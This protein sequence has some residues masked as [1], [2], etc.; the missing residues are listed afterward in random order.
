ME[1]DK[2]PS[3]LPPQEDRLDTAYTRML[4][5]LRGGGEEGG[6][7][8]LLDRLGEAKE[9][10]IALGELT[11]EEAERVGDYLRRDLTDAAEYMAR[12]GRELKDWLRFDLGLIEERL[13]GLFSFMVDHTRQELDRFATQAR[14]ADAFHTGELTAMGTL[15]CEACGQELRLKGPRHLP[16]CPKCHGTRFRRVST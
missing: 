16:P 11:R 7:P 3:D 8:R 1:P 12:T 13:L 15:R 6:L 10:A 4:E 5:R 14:E 9:R 2:P